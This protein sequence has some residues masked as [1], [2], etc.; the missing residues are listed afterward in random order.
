MP[1]PKLLKTPLDQKIAGL[2]LTCEKKTLA[3]WAIECAE[4]ALSNFEKSYPPDKRPRQAIETLKEWLKTGVFSMAVIRKASLN[5]HAAA[6]MAEAN[7]DKVACAAARAC[8]QCVA[9]A[10]V[11]THALGPGIYGT[12]AVYLKTG[13]MDEAIVERE[14]Q[15]QRLKELIKANH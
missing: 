7:G 4:R 8:G 13:S 2:A 14:W 3:L 5:A 6:R 9:T 1:S 12:T 15:Y 11:K 10:H